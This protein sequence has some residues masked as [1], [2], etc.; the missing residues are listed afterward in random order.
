MKL[1]RPFKTLSVMAGLWL[2]AAVFHAIALQSGPFSFLDLRAYDKFFQ[3]RNRLDAPSP[4]D[5]MVIVSIDD[6]SMAEIGLQWPWPRAIHGDLV[7]ALTRAGA[8]V[9]AF[10]VVF[11]TPADEA[12]DATF[13]DAIARSK[14]V[15]L[16]EDYTITVEGAYQQENWVRPL[17][18]FLDPARGAGLV[19]IHRDPDGFLR[20][21]LL[22]QNGIPSFARVIAESYKHFLGQ[23][24]SAVNP[25]QTF[26]LPEADSRPVLINYLGPPRAIKTVSYYQVL[27][28]EK[29]LP[30]GMFQ[31]KIV[32]VG[33]SLSAGVDLGA[34]DHFLYPFMT[35]HRSPISGVEVQASLVDTLLRE[36]YLKPLPMTWQWLAF[37]TLLALGALILGAQ[38]PYAIPAFFGLVLLFA[39]G[40]FAL[41]FSQGTVTIA[42][43]PIISFLFFFGME[44]LYKIV[45]VDREKRFVKKAFK[46]YVSPAVVDQLIRNPDQLNLYGEYYETTVVFTDLVG[47]TSLSERMEPFELL[48]FLTDYFTEMVDI[49]IANRGTLDK[50]IGDALMCFFGVPIRSPEHAIQGVTTAWEMHVRL[51]ELNKEWE[52]AGRPALGMRLGV[53]SGQVVAGNMGTST[54]FNYTIMGDTV[55]LCAR[56]ESANKAYGTHVMISEFTHA[57]VRDHFDTRKL[58]LIRVK[59]KE[60][61]VT[62][63][64]LLGPRGSL[65]PETARSVSDYEEAFEAHLER[66]FQEAVRILEALLSINQDRPAKVLLARC[67]QYLASP[68]GE[69]WNGVYTMKTK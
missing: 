4:P 35:S 15:I 26:R 18:R 41:F 66:N 9:I 55:N 38:R 42:V 65:P 36:R 50:F 7:D 51:L 69:D 60:K 1:K 2:I 34:A 13:E 64:E 29:M 52:K 19:L 59:G 33:R 48:R 39:L 10:D 3:W 20:R 53:N 57:L 21:A 25:G 67:R 43:T 40:S 62:I 58:D 47:F 54:L 12:G 56:L 23:P 22:T 63:Y 49:M 46:H 31:D 8:A 28:S 32:L 45:I 5:N 27:A 61:P 16:A 24:V 68:P 44:R 37:A 14:K 6:E 17:D 30:Q 11:D